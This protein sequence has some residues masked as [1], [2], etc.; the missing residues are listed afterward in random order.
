MTDR[1]ESSRSC[2]TGVIA[3]KL[4]PRDTANHSFE[5]T[6]KTHIR[7][8]PR[9]RHHERFRPIATTPGTPSTLG[10]GSPELNTGCG[11]NPT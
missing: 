8:M 7:M 10:N 5:T 2:R 3:K 11:R 4:N 9:F 1:P 6:C